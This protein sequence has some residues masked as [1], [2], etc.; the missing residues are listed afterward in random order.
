MLGVRLFS[1]ISLFVKEFIRNAV[2]GYHYLSICT[3]RG[4]H[5]NL[6]IRI[7]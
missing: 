6:F 2:L 5:P 1:F 4:I 7:R 3:S